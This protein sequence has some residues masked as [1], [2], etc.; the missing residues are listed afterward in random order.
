MA[1]EI[2]DYVQPLFDLYGL[3]WPDVDEDAFHDMQGPLAEFGRDLEAVGDAIEDALNLLLSGNPSQTLGA[4]VHYVGA[5][6]S[7]YLSPIQRICSDLAGEPCDLAYDMVVGVKWTIIG[8]LTGEVA[9]DIIDI[10]EAILTLGLASGLSIAQAVAVREAL[11]RCLK[12]AEGDIAGAVVSCANGYLDNFVSSLISP[13][14]SYVSQGLE[15]EIETYAPRLLLREAL[16]TEQSLYEEA[17]RGSDRLHVA[18]SELEHC[19]ASII[20]SSVHL[21]GAEKKLQAALDELFANPA[22]NAPSLPHG[23]SPELRHAL[24]GVIDTVKTDLITAIRQLID[25]IV[26]H[27]VQLLRDYWHMLQE[28]DRLARDLASKQHAGVVPPVMIGSLVGI[29]VVDAEVVSAVASYAAQVADV[30]GETSR[31]E[32]AVDSAEALVTTVTG[33]VSLVAEEQAQAMGV[34]DDNAAALV[35]E[36]VVAQPSQNVQTEVV[37]FMEGGI[38]SLVLKDAPAPPQMG[39]ADSG[40]S[41]GT[42][43]NQIAGGQ[44]HATAGAPGQAQATSQSVTEMSGTQPHEGQVMVDPTVANANEIVE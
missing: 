4:L 16:S 31:I 39:V 2:P 30:E 5:I 22:P 43:V 27:F 21:D 37:S 20:S 18:E 10:G 7:D 3:P 33:R 44:P 38:E 35:D 19:I 42:G 8:M 26:K 9:S 41:Q 1:L 6:R 25:H 14:I 13:F 36:L 17:V 40:S 28:L 24:K 34:A 23:L 12:A 32:R 11:S 29:G 15:R